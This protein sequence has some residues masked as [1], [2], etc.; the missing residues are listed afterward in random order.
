[1]R[2][3]D[4]Q[5]VPEKSN[6]LMQE[7]KASKVQGMKSQCPALATQGFP[8]SHLETAQ[9]CPAWCLGIHST[10]TVS[11]EYDFVCSSTFYILQEGLSQDMG[12][13]KGM[14]RMKI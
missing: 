5:Y 6:S 3:N 14:R 10:A 1:M 8:K 12:R 4:P 13:N 2:K 7:R 11:K 9:Q